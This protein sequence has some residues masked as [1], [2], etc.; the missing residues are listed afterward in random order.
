MKYID[1]DTWDRTLHYN[2]FKDNVQPQYSIAF[3]L[4][5]THFLKI[6]KEKGYSFTFAFIYAVSFCA[7]KIENFRY[8]FLDD[9]PVLY[10]EIETCFNYLNQETELFKSI[11]VPMQDSMET[12][13]KLAKETAEKQKEYF[14]PG[15]NTNSIYRFSPIPWIEFTYISHTESGGKSNGT[16]VFNWGKYFEKEGKVLL[17]FE[18]KVHHSFVDG[19]HIGKLNQILQEYLNTIV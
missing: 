10:D 4:D 14:L 7:N 9:K 11:I 16:P 12:Y 8:R 18:V 6:V 13:V 1:L 3:Y 17:P 2:I 5:I 19:I 15:Q